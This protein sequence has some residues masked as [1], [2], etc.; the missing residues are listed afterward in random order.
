MPSTWARVLRRQIRGPSDHIARS[1]GVIVAILHAGFTMLPRLIG[2]D[3]LANPYP[4]YSELR[5]SH[6]VFRDA[7]IGAEVVETE[8][9]DADRFQ[10]IGLRSLSLIR[11]T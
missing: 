8:K 2:P 9:G 3:L 10:G 11:S 6:P 4:I 5:S 1:M 7:E